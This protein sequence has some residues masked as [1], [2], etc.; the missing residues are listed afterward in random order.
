MSMKI[1]VVVYMYIYICM[2]VDFSINVSY[3]SCM[4]ITLRIVVPFCNFGGIQSFHVDWY[5]W[6][7]IW[8]WRSKRELVYIVCV[9]IR[10]RTYKIY[11]YIEV[12]FSNFF[13]WASLCC[14][15]KLKLLLLF[16]SLS[17]SLSLLSFSLTLICR[18]VSP[19]RLS[20]FVC[21]LVCDKILGI[22][23][24]LFVLMFVPMN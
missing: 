20:L 11:S 13:W 21:L 14:S 24:L 15:L 8:Q 22:L 6:K 16:F 4:S 9:I 1:C 7:T 12:C 10:V 5:R 17:L 3:V 23:D 19:L 2:C 18:S